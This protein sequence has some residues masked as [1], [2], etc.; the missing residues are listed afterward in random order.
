MSTQNIHNCDFCQKTSYNADKII[1]E[2]IVV[3]GNRL[4]KGTWED[5]CKSCYEKLAKFIL[6]LREENENA[7]HYQKHTRR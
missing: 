6:T 7:R 2:R 4:H 5:I 3:D 1:H